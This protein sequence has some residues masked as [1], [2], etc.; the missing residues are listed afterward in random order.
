MGLFSKKYCDI[1][2]EQIRFLGNR[3][4]EDGNM[5]KACAE[6]LSP[7][8]SDRRRT[9]VED[10]KKQ[11]AYREENR[12]AVAAFRQTRVFGE[13]G[14]V[15]I[16]DTHHTFIPLRNG[17]RMSDNPDVFD[18]SAVTACTWHAQ[19]QRTEH[20]QKDAEGKQVSYDPPR[21]TYSYDFI[22]DL[23]V[24]H[25]YADE[26][27][28][29]INRSA[30]KIDAGFPIEKPSLFGARTQ[31]S[32]TPPDTARNAEYQRY[33]AMA[34]EICAALTGRESAVPQTPAPSLQQLFKAASAPDA[35]RTCPG[36]SASVIPEN[37]CCPYCSTPLD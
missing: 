33:A 26:I 34:E 30:V 17:L 5:C 29:R 19:E 36:C 22:L 11:L 16:D 7:W 35:K 18:F 28:F 3:K 4:V 8:F 37:G 13:E 25:P 6:K 14:T 27:R 12:S 9:T 1:C 21:Y 15:H 24:N 23:N 2:G 20:K 32:P 31:Y 10:I